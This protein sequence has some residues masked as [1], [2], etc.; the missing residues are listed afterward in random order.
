[1]RVVSSGAGWIRFAD[2]KRIGLACGIGMLALA[3]GAAPAQGLPRLDITALGMHAD[4]RVVRPGQI[5]HVIVHVHVREKRDRLDELVLPALT[6]A[7]DLG[8]ERR[9]V[10]G[11][12]GTDFYETLTVTASTVGSASFSP[13]Y[14]DAIDPAS[15][16]ALRFSSQP[17]TVRVASGTAVEDADPGA[18]MRLLRRAVLFAGGLLVLLAFGIV[19]LVRLRRRPPPVIQPAPPP[20]ARKVAPPADPLRE[21]VRAYRSQRDGA[22]LDV[23][24]N[25]LFARAGAAAGGTFADALNALGS[26]DPQL[27]R[28]MAVAERARF[29]PDHERAP[30]ARDL[31]ALLDA[32]LPEREPVG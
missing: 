25:A 10:P 12:D 26:R 15:G 13:A 24:R 8:D 32:Y 1:M 23:L 2:A 17:L 16:R 20:A 27:A 4:A 14:I 3:P 30:A 6:N 28:V 21:A 19:A 31:I 29:G 9:R 11:P 5:F 22:A 18:L 7:V